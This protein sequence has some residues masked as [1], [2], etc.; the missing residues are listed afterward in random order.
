MK[1]SQVVF[2]EWIIGSIIGVFGPC[3]CSFYFPRAFSVSLYWFRILYILE[4]STNP[5]QSQHWLL[6]ATSPI[7]GV[8]SGRVG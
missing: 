4:N 5:D 1:F 6:C 3:A 2:V 8:I 7:I